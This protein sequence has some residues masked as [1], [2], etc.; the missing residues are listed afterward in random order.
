MTPNLHPPVALVSLKEENV[1]KLASLLSSEDDTLD[2]VVGRCI[3]AMLSSQPQVKA[4][5][6][7]SLERPSQVVSSEAKTAETRLDI[8]VRTKVVEVFGE[9]ISA[10]SMGRLFRDL[11]DL[12]HDLDPCVIQR[13]SAKKAKVRRFVA[14]CPERI[15]GGRMDLP[16]LQTESGWWVSDNIGTED[17]KRALRALCEAGGLTY[18]NDIRYIP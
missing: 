15:H 6:A 18:G 3:E 17:L 11:V 5:K 1:T 13:L 14:N 16:T 9:R 4:S 12:I 10:P 7:V 8:A 2:A